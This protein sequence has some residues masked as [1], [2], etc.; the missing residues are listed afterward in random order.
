[1]A[2]VRVPLN[3]RDVPCATL[4]K[5]PWDFEGRVQVD[6]KEPFPS[7]DM[8]SPVKSTLD[9]TDPAS[10]TSRLVGLMLILGRLSTTE[11][12]AFGISLTF[13]TVS[14]NNPFISICNA[15][16]NVVSA[17]STLGGLSDMIEVVS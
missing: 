17:L 11:G 16:L 5:E 2:N 9:D 13:P 6:Y 3:V 8:M 14:P 15:S 1:V 7:G 12:H 10:T 4:R